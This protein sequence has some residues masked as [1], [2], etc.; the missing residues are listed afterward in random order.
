[1]VDDGVFRGHELRFFVGENNSH[2]FGEIIN[3]YT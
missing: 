3:V 2:P 1:M